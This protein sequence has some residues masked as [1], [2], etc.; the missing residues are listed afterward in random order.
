MAQRPSLEKAPG[1]F[2]WS[3]RYQVPVFIAQ[4]LKLSVMQCVL[5][6]SIRF[7][8]RIGDANGAASSDAPRSHCRPSQCDTLTCAPRRT[9][10]VQVT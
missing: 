2:L 9:R 3:V 1:V 7:V 6:H 10:V 4:S 8:S 5:F